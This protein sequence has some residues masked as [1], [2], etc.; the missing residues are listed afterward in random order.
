MVWNAFDSQQG[1]AL[2]WLFLLAALA[3]GRYR[4][5]TDHGVVWLELRPD[6]RA[7]YGGA[8]YLWHA[9]PGSLV[10][11]A[12]EGTL[13][14]TLRDTPAGPVLVGPPFGEVQLTPVD[15][16]APAEAPPAAPPT[17]PWAGT[18]QHTAS[19]GTLAL[20]LD[21]DGT[22]ELRQQFGPT[23]PPVVSGGRWSG[24]ATSLV[25]TPEG[26]AP[27]RYAAR[28]EAAALLLSGGD[29]PFEVRLEAR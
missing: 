17:A 10:L 15:W 26:G 12:P 29:L 18:W 27:L 5:V 20:R 11:A 14:L 6:G 9:E 13:T 25:L 1:I 23:E 22:Y 16:P 7:V 21:P 2:L 4:G 8:A 19:G 24:D 28:R 3:P